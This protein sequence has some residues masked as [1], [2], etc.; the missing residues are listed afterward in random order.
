MTNFFRFTIL[1]YCSIFIGFSS[2][3]KKKEE[4]KEEPPAPIPSPSACFN[5]SKTLIGLNDFIQFQNCSQNYDRF[6]W[7]F[8]DGQS[9]VLFEPSHFWLTKGTYEV[10]LY[11]F[12]GS[13]SKKSQKKYLLVKRSISTLTLNSATG[14]S[15]QNIRTIE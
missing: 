10:S 7:N 4:K 5:P 1:I 2:S 8:G 12:K 3:C 11:A 15:P 9:S 14:T 6:E 13:E